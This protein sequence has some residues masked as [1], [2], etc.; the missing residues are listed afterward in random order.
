MRYS[1]NNEASVTYVTIMRWNPSKAVWEKEYIEDTD[2]MPGLWPRL[3]GFHAAEDYFVVNEPINQEF[4]LNNNVFVHTYEWIMIYR[5]NEA[6]RSWRRTYIA[7]S[8]GC[9]DPPNVNGREF[10]NG[11]FHDYAK[12]FF[13]DDYNALDY[14][15]CNP[16]WL[17]FPR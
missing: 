6:E 10:A 1:H 9:S 16:R 15:R 14:I 13:D 12:S 5:Y 8:N 11:V 4:T 3:A 2:V 17:R 7:K